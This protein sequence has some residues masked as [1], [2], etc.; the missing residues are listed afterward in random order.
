MISL[1]DLINRDLKPKNSQGIY[2]ILSSQNCDYAK[3]TSLKKET[4]DIC[5]YEDESDDLKWSLIQYTLS[6]DDIKNKRFYMIGYLIKNKNNKPIGS[7]NV[8]FSPHKNDITIVDRIGGKFEIIL[9]NNKNEHKL[10]DTFEKFPGNDNIINLLSQK[11]KDVLIDI[12]N[13]K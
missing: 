6:G 13:N 7:L 12:I 11:L 10:V 2:Q 4:P 5:L 1:H 9:S 8:C 3:I